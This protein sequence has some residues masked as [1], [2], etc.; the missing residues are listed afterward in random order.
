LTDGNEIHL[1]G[2]GSSNNPISDQDFDLKFKLLAR[3][4][5]DDEQATALLGQCWKV[6]ALDDV[7]MLTTS[8]A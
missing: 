8:A 2:T 1:Y 4:A 6:A 5:I 3:D 7:G